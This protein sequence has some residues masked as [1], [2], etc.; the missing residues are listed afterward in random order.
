MTRT[1][2]GYDPSSLPIL[3]SVGGQA[4]DVAR[5]AMRELSLAP[6]DR[7][8]FERAQLHGTPI[9]ETVEQSLCQRMYQF[10]CSV[11]GEG[12]A[13]RRHRAAREGLASKK[14]WLAVRSFC[15]GHG[16][17]DAYA[18]HVSTNLPTCQP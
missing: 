5:G 4:G 1:F 7:K 16:I 11:D 17:D 6:V 8:P 2:R 9:G 15:S 14:L 10:P 3:K 12:W 13:F 18:C